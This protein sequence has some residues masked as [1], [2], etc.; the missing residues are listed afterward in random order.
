MPDYTHAQLLQIYE[1]TFAPVGDPDE[2]W[3]A[4]VLRWVERVVRASSIDAAAALVATWTGESAQ[5]SRAM[6]ARIWEHAG[7]AVQA[8]APIS[9]WVAV[10]Q[11]AVR[12]AGWRWWSA[13]RLPVFTRQEDGQWPA[14]FADGG[15]LTAAQEAGRE[16]VPDLCDPAV[17]GWLLGL[18][19]RHSA[20]RSVCPAYQ[21]RGLRWLVVGPR[22]DGSFGEL[23]QAGE[24][25]EAMLMMLARPQP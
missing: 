23:G 12:C 24:E 2:E 18:L 13:H 22:P 15:Q 1:S 17:R 25:V 14:G 5:E 9:P 20:L 4:D 6:A 19:R 7:L 10:G 3:L 16:V 21:P 8:R 11:R